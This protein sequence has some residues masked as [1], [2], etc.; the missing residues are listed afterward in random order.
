MLM[1]NWRRYERQ[2]HII[3]SNF[4]P[5]GI[6]RMQGHLADIKTSPRYEALMLTN[7]L[8]RSVR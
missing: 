8:K 2:R 4:L 1:M 6:L 5:G 7:K 3:L